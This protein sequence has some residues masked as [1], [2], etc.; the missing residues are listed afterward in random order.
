MKTRTLLLLALGCGVAI[1]LAGAVLLFQLVTRDDISEPVPVGTPADVGDVRATVTG[2]AEAGGTLTVGVMLEAP[3]GV[4]PTTGFRLI[5][6][7]RAVAPGSVTCP[8]ECTIEFDVSGADGTSR[9]L[10]YER[11]DEQARWVLG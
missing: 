10:F 6:S 7:G 9:V 8:D 4:D 2:A 11:G 1:M 5:A 3:D